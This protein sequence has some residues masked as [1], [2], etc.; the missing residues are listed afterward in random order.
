MSGDDVETWTDA[1]GARHA[2]ADMT[3]AH[4]EAAL[5]FAADQ[6][7]QRFDDLD[8]VHSLHSRVS[9]DAAS[10]EVDMAIHAVDEAI[11]VAC[12]RLDLM[13]STLRSRGVDV[14]PAGAGR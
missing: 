11:G 3:T 12:D 8:A 2:I 10:R 14:G 7:R 13:I 9:G 1:K 6:A 5:P 4:L